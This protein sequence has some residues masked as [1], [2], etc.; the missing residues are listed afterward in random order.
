MFSGVQAMSMS[1]MLKVWVL[2]AA[3]VAL[4]A[5]AVDAQP[6]KGGVKQAAVKKSTAVPSTKVAKATKAGVAGT[7]VAAAA[8]AHPPLTDAELAVAANV[9][10]GELPCELGQKVSLQSDDKNP[11]YFNL[12]LKQYRFHMHPV[13]TTTGAVRLE[14]QD[15]GAVWIQVANK[16]MLMSQKEGRRLADECV[17]P[18][19]QAVADA[20]KTNPPPSLLE[21]AQSPR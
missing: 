17:S 15:K 13:A 19:Q 10:V 18:V 8:L 11:G 14:D 2:A 12:A 16:S 21:V 4:S 1:S 3:G 6:T 7:A 9:Y 5:G 20:M